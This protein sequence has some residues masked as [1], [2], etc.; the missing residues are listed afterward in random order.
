MACGK[1]VL[2]N[3]GDLFCISS[4]LYF[5][6]LERYDIRPRYFLLG[7]NYKQVYGVFR[8]MKKN[9]TPSVLYSPPLSTRLFLPSQSSLSESLYCSGKLYTSMVD[10]CRK[11]TW[12][13]NRKAI[14][15]Q[16]LYWRNHQSYWK[17][18]STSFLQ[19]EMMWRNI[20]LF[21]FVPLTDKI[22]VLHVRHAFQSYFFDVVCQ[23]DHK[24]NEASS[25]LTYLKTG[26]RHHKRVL[27][28]TSFEKGS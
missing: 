26:C 10:R 18:S 6:I 7:I 11:Y 1:R 4:V 25:F 14:S 8:E 22:I 15:G 9:K 5:T 20:T 2:E 17:G 21:N 23:I 27:K 28:A 24:T 16:R 19:L 12:K 3:G 13:L